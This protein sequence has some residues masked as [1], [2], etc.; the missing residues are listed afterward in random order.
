MLYVEQVDYSDA[1]K[2]RLK[3]SCPDVEIERDEFFKECVVKFNS[4]FIINVIDTETNEITKYRLSDL[5]NMS[6]NQVY[7][8]NIKFWKSNKGENCASIADLDVLSLRLESC[9][10]YHKVTMLED[11]KGYGMM[12]SFNGS[13]CIAYDGKHIVYYLD[14]ENTITNK[15]VGLSS[16]GYSALVLSYTYPY[17]TLSFLSLYYKGNLVEKIDLGGYFSSKAILSRQDVLELVDKM[18]SYHVLHKET[19]WFNIIKV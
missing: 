8:P 9:E 6:A 1:M 5:C 16:D 7:I 13:K 17:N 12:F 11:P 4:S 19:R 2:L 10:Y 3:L 15:L 14:N 18:R